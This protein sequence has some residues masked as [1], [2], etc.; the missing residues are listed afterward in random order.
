MWTAVRLTR[1]G[2]ALDHPKSARERRFEARASGPLHAVQ[3]RIP[4]VGE[5]TYIFN[6]F[7]QPGK[8]A[9]RGVPQ[10]P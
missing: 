3:L 2:V 6:R 5:G 4:E 9:P 7:R 10:R 8:R 1:L